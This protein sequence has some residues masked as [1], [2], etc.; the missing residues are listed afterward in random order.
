MFDRE[1]DCVRTQIGNRIRSRRKELGITQC[2]L[3]AA[4]GHSSSSRINQIELGR[5]RLYAEE[6]PRLCR[7]LQ[8]SV[9]DLVPPE[10]KLDSSSA[11]L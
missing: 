3:A 7:F 5:K 2:E 11:V 1:L 9:G 4:L 10:A 8:C 6:L